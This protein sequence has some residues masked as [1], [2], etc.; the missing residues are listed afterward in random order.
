MAGQADRAG[1]AA[2]VVRA[3]AGDPP[4][5]GADPAARGPGARPDPALGTDGEAAR[6]RADQDLRRDV[7]TELRIGPGDDRG[8]DR[9]PAQPP[10][11]GRAGQ[12]LA[13]Q[14]AG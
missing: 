14:E 12:G 11:P 10:G 6:T 5:A 1:H 9:R 8:A 2:P 7:G 3:A 13:A 4:A